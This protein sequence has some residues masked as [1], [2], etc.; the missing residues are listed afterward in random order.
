MVGCG[1]ASEQ[2]RTHQIQDE[3][4]RAM[5]IESPKLRQREGHQDQDRARHLE[6]EVD[7]ADG[8][9]VPGVRMFP[10]IGLLTIGTS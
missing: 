4:E 5:A 9:Q 2:S 1:R 10:M 8:P 3:I 6:H 7:H